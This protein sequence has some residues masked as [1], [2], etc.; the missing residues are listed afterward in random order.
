MDKLKKYIETNR[1]LFETDELPK[2][3]FDRFEKRLDKSKKKKYSLFWIMTSFSAA[4]ILALLVLINIAE[5]KPAPTRFEAE[6][7]QCS[8]SKEIEELQIYYNMNM[9]DI[10]SEMEKISKENSSEGVK[11]ILKEGRK[12]AMDAKDFEVHVL[13]ALPCSQLTL[14]VISQQY[15]ANIESLNMMLE[16][17]KEIE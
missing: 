10:L 9:F 3:S 16:Q 2:G 4:A 15:G 6:S 14:S 13:P 7:N 12:V 5:N 17:M 1:D 11:T 8:I